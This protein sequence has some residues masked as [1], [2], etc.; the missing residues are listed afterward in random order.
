MRSGRSSLTARFVALC[1]GLGPLLPASAQLVKDPDGARALGPAVARAIEG[2]AGLPSPL[3]PLLWTPLLPLLPWALYMQVR[4]RALDDALLRFAR[5]GGRQVV[6]LGAGF[7]ARAD[8]LSDVAPE[9][10]YFEVDHP[11]T[12]A[13]K[14]ELFGRRSGASQLA[15]DFERDALSDL[16]GAL[17]ARGLDPEEPCFTLLEGVS[18]YLSRSAFD[19]TLDSVRAYSAARSQLAFNYVERA[20]IERPGVAARVVG[21]VVRAVGEPFRLGFEPGELAD[22]LRARGFDVLW[23]E[24]FDALARAQ[25]PS[26][27]SSMIGVGR[28]LTVIERSLTARVR[29]ELSR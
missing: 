11:A 3:R 29:D 2:L 17:I 6:I 25:L 23:D 27:W 4:T 22:E 1:R 15:W 8:R 12:Q 28:R 14:R 18:M 24:S 26:P 16:P 9:L 5:D 7:D 19:A 20:L 21:G 10:R 13:A